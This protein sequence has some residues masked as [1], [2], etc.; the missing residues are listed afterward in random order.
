MPNMK[1]IANR[2]GVSVATVSKVLNGTGNISEET[3]R[4]ILEIAEELNYHPNLYA[5]NLKTG[6]SRTI[7]ILAE[8]LTVFNTPPVI[9]GI[10][11]CCEE[12]GYRYL[13]ENLRINTLGIDPDSDKEKYTVIKNN[14]ISHMSSM[15]VDGIIYLGCHSH[16]VVPSVFDNDIPFVCAYCISPSLAIPSVLYDDQHAA[17]EAVSLLIGK[18]H[19]RIGTITGKPGSVHT[20]WRLTGYQESL[21]DHDIPYN[22]GYVVSGDWSRDSG[23][24]A[25][26]EL[27][28]KKVTAIFSHNDEMALGVID[29]C[30]DSKVQVGKDIALIGFDNREL[31]TVCRPTLTTVEPPLYDIGYKSAEGLIAKKENKEDKLRGEVR[32]PCRIIERDST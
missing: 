23:Y 6:Y 7:G 21:Y 17:Y 5:R 27:I 24:N 9:D 13:L 2:A 20:R 11:A 31:S 28:E 3:T 4:K 10:G 22:P 15:Q 12:K 32:L 26:R 8:D 30:N 18:G 25:A 1:D 19:T 29:A 16:R 14:A